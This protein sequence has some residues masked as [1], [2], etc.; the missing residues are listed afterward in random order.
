MQVVIGDSHSWLKLYDFG[1]QE[2]RIPIK[3][4]RAHHCT[5]A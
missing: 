2:H 1:D 3:V 4:D 5:I